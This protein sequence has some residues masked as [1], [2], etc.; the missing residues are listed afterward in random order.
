MKL[1]WLSTFSFAVLA[2]VAFSQT[3][4]P[5]THAH[6]AGITLHIRQLAGTNGHHIVEGAFKAFGR[7]LAQAVAVNSRVTGVPSTKGVI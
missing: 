3:P 4:L 2:T 7:A 1:L 6:N 5:N